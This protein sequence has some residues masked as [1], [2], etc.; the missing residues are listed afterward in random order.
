LLI[1]DKEGK[2]FGNSIKKWSPEKFQA[3]ISWLFVGHLKGERKRY[4]KVSVIKMKIVNKNG[5]I[6]EKMSLTLDPK[7]QQMLRDHM[8][9]C[10]FKSFRNTSAVVNKIL[11]SFLLSGFAKDLEEGK[12]PEGEEDFYGRENI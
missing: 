12:K 8:M 11:E 10:G 7:V 4:I 2:N 5:T 9:K 3:R 6:K 1:L